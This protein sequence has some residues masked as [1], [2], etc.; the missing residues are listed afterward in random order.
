MAKQQLTALVP[1]MLVGALL[2]WGASKPAQANAARPAD[3]LVQTVQFYPNGGFYGR[4]YYGRFYG[5]GFF[6]PRFYGPRFVGPG[7]Y[8][9]RFFG[10]GF[11]RYRG[12][13]GFYG[14]SF[15]R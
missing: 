10:P 12:Y 7:F 3:S 9:P 8:G 4:P 14:R 6:R 2:F 13:G 11:Y 15:Y 5:P 1:A